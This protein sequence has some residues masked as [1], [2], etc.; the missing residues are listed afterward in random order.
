MVLWLCLVLVPSVPLSAPREPV[1][2]DTA[3]RVN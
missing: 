2:A 3:T 1:S